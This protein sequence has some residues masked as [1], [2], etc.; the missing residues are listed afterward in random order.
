MLKKITTNALGQTIPFTES[1]S[2]V[3]LKEDTF[4]V[5]GILRTEQKIEIENLFPLNSNHL[6]VLQIFD[7]GVY[8]L[9]PSALSKLQKY[10]PA[11]RI[12][13]NH[14]TLEEDQGKIVFLLDDGMLVV[15]QREMI[16]KTPTISPLPALNPYRKAIYDFLEA[17]FPEDIEAEQQ[18]LY[19]CPS[20][21]MQVF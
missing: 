8:K 21:F 15:G 17:S 12:E 7:N 13:R 2:L 9:T 3:L 16:N 14:N 10:D 1:G 4:S 20:F 6:A 11:L 19:N 18:L 5:L